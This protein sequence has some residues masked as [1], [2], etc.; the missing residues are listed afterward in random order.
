MAEKK[1][2]L[3]RKLFDPRKSA[4]SGFL[5]RGNALFND[6]TALISLL[7]ALPMKD[8]G[9]VR[10]CGVAKRGFGRAMKRKK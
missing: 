7:G 4:G 2:G 5:R 6:S 10:G 8:G 1:I 9:R 3:L